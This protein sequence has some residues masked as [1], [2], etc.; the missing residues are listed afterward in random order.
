MDYFDFDLRIGR[1]EQGSYSLALIASPGGESSARL[2]LPVDDPRLRSCL[3]AMEEGIY[4]ETRGL[5]P[6]R[7][8]VPAQPLSVAV[9]ALGRALF[10][11]LTH[12]RSVYACY[13]TSLV[14]AQSQ[15]K[16]LRLR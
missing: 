14:Q 11:S 10:D 3:E 13:H 1:G 7:L 6:V 15:G 4:S 12:E 16:G 2:E 8:G 5:A 9:Q